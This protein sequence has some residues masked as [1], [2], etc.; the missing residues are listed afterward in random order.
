MASVPA[1]EKLYAMDDIHSL[2]DG[3][4]AELTGSRIYHMT[5]PDTRHHNMKA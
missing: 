5:P 1:Q 4:K 3:S 2:P